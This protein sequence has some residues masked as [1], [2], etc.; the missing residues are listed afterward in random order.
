V[1][2]EHSQ[3]GAEALEGYGFARFERG[4]E[5]E[6][7]RTQQRAAD[8]PEQPG[9]QIFRGSGEQRGGV[10]GGNEFAPRV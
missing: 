1:F 8:M 4:G 6:T 7:R 3:C 9:T 5:R 2:A 10:A